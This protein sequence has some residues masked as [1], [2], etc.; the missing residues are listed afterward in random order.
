MDFMTPVAGKPQM[1]SLKLRVAAQ[2]KIDAPQQVY[3]HPVA[4]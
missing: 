1:A 3:V 2:V 4:Q